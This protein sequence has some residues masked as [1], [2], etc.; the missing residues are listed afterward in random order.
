MSG[1]IQAA[2]IA[3]TAA[4]LAL[5][6]KRDAPAIAFLMSLAAGI[7]ILLGALQMLQ[8]VQSSLQEFLHT[9]EITSTFYVPVL[10][11]VGIAVVIRIAADFCR[12]TGQAALA[13]K[14]ELMGALAALTVTMP[15]FTQILQLVTG[16]LG[17]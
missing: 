2:G 6:L 16:M 12:D 17:G 10:K 5:L 9:A 4:I 13:A 3:L 8:R 7:C 14:L 1:V 15:L 11:A